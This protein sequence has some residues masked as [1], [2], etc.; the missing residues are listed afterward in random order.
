MAYLPV[1]DDIE[2]IAGSTEGAG[3]NAPLEQ[4]LTVKSL[5][6]AAAENLGPELTQAAFTRED[7]I[8]AARVDL[9]MLAAICDPDGCWSKFPSV[10][11][12]VFNLIT[13]SLMEMRGFHRFAFGIPRGFCKTT[14]LKLAVVWNILYGDRRFT[15]VV[16]KTASHAEN[17]IAGVISMLEHPNVLSTFGRWNSNATTLR[18]D[19]KVFNFR[20]RNN[21]LVAISSEG[22]V[23]GINIDNERPDFIL[24]DDIQSWENAESALQS[25]ALLTWMTGSLMKA[26]N[27]TRCVYAFIGNM[28]PFAGSILRKLKYNDRWTSLIAGGLLADGESLWPELQSKEQLLDEYANDLALGKGTTFLAEI[29]ND[30]TANSRLTIDLSLV[31]PMTD[32][33]ASEEPQGKFI[34]IDPSNDK[35]NSDKSEIG[36]FYVYDGKPALMKHVA[37]RMNPG[38]LIREALTIAMTYNVRVIAVE[39]IA[40]Q[41]SLLYWFQQVMNQYQISGIELVELYASG[42]KNARIKNMISLLVPKKGQQ[43]PDLM[44]SKDVYNDVIYEIQ[45]WNP[46]KTDNVDDLLDILAYAYKVIELYGAGIATD[47]YTTILENGAIKSLELSDN[48]LF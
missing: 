21:I 37:G 2:D 28:Y 17:F 32:T 39:S 3:V 14:L 41:Y 25:D 9:N 15:A 47:T 31:Q 8:A 16:C 34:V 1:L 24:M 30:E 12:T 33:L 6:T 26:A 48:S 42:S 19:L 20:G 43:L 11:T 38:T 18:N 40:F 22:S 23:R 44:L 5:S 13:S 4:Q 29:L 45:Q 7:V 10:H 46:I 27:K 36:L 35:K